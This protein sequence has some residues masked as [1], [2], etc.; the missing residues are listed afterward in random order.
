[1][2]RFC[3]VFECH[4]ARFQLDFVVE[5]VL[6]VLWDG[7]GPKRGIPKGIGASDTA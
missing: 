6:F 2:D 1:M 7:P 4:C 5:V 3:R